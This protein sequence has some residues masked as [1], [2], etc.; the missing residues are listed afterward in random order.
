MGQVKERVY[1]LQRVKV[2]ERSFF[3]RQRQNDAWAMA[4]VRSGGRGGGWPMR[5]LQNE[6]NAETVVLA[7]SREPK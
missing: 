7:G 6:A 1:R 4:A 3:A 5:V 2:S